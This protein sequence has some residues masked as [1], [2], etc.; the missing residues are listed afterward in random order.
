M[1]PKKILDLLKED[2]E[3]IKKMLDE[4]TK[5][6]HKKCAKPNGGF[7][8]NKMSEMWHKGEW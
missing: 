5:E 3:E 2:E 8:Y 7:D 4:S 6:K 1:T